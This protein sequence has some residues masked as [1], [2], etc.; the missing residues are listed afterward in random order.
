[1][2]GARIVPLLLSSGHTVAGMTRSRS[3]IDTLRSSG[4]L[5]V[6][7]DVF[8]YGSLSKAVLGFSPDLI[9]HQL[10]DLPDSISKIPEYSTAN[11]RIRIEGTDNLISAAKLA[12]VHRFL[13]QSI[14]WEIPAQGAFAKQHLEDSVLNYGGV[15]LRYGQLYGPGTYYESRPPVGPTIHVDE[16]ARRTVLMLEHETGIVNLQED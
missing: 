1:M 15:V 14:A 5:P 16:A 11:N 13:A 7:C 6:L 3:K 12:K 9:M 2:L 8:D 10:T 4:C